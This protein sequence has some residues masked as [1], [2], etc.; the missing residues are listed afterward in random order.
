M[1]FSLKEHL[2]LKRQ[3]AG[4]VSTDHPEIRKILIRGFQEIQIADLRQFYTGSTLA[5]AF[6]RTLLWLLR[7]FPVLIVDPS[8]PE[9]KTIS[10]PF[11][12]KIVDKVNYLLEVLRNQ[13]SMLKE[14]NYPVQVQMEEDR[15]PFFRIHN[16]E[17]VP[18]HRDETGD[19]SAESISPSALLRPLFQDYLFPTLG[20]VGG[21]AEIAYFAQLHPWYGAMNMIQPQ[22]FARASITLIPPATRSFLETHKLQPEEMYLPED[23]LVDAL[24]NH[25]GMKQMRKHLKDLQNMLK[26]A[27]PKLQ[28]EANSIDPTLDKG[29]ETAFRKMEYQLS[30]MER[31]TFFAAKRKNLVLAEQI[32]KAKNVIYPDD[33]LQERYLSIFSFSGRLPEMVRQIYDQIQW[34]MKAHQ[35]IEV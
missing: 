34:D 22:L 33:K 21:P 25:E 28:E 26:V 30:K 23:T 32:R 31:K 2:F 12:E 18:V 35:W 9:L 5:N 1:R 6:A 13:N 10:A 4:T 3:P 14:R 16:Q 24:L 7:D 17:R 20:Y 15:M 27:L 11:F 8:D 19:L 29:L